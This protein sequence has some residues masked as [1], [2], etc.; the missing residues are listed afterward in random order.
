MQEVKEM[1]FSITSKSGKAIHIRYPAIVD[2]EPM[3]DYIN[4]LSKE[5]TFIRFQGEEMS[6]EEETRYLEGELQK[7]KEHQTVMLLAFSENRL[8]GISGIHM[9]DK[10]ERHV[11][12]FGISIAKEFRQDGIGALLMQHT[13][14]EAVKMI[15][16]LEI[17]TLCLF[18]HNTVGF[19][20]YKKFG[21]LQYGQLPQGIKL[22][23]GYVDHI[24]MYKR[25]R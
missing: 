6:L 16:A 19:E 7:I 25:V 8:I 21:F 22:G 4:T 18:S 11:G 24:M 17:V 2:A 14:D 9:S 23:D 13:L 10:T 12:L 20:M 3:C 1:N 5:K 15:P